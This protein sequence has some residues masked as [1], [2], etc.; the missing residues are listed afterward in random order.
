MDDVLT[1][2]MQSDFEEIYDVYYDRIY[3]YAY[4][5]LLNKEDAED[6]TEDTFLSAYRNFASFNAEKGSLGTWLSRIAHNCAVN[7][8]RSAAYSKKAEIPD[9]WDVEEEGDFTKELDYSDEI[10]RLYAKLSPE[11][12]EFLNLRYAMDLKDSEVA[13]LMGLNEKAVNKRYQRLLTKCRTLI[14]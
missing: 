13:A 7:L 12:R 3:R 11:E 4:T 8:V 6:V 1:L 9:S 10:I 5:L 14:D 2:K